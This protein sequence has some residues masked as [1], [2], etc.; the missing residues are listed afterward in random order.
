M[1]KCFVSL[2]LGVAS[3]STGLACWLRSAI[4]NVWPQITQAILA[5]DLLHLALQHT[6]MK[7]NSLCLQP[8]LYT[9]TT[10]LLQD[11]CHGYYIADSCQSTCTFCDMW[12]VIRN[13][14]CGSLTTQ[15]RRTGL[16]QLCSCT[17]RP[18]HSTFHFS[19][20][21]SWNRANLSCCILNSLV[22]IE[23]SVFQTLHTHNPWIRIYVCWIL[24]R[25]II[26]NKN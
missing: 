26:N 3:L 9:H 13:S 17:T 18:I 7:G 1:T 2:Q 6:G 5:Q 14:T 10:E 25:A 20:I 11:L 4:K 24:L 12:L 23:W 22:S 19:F 8:V 16:T 21:S 15:L